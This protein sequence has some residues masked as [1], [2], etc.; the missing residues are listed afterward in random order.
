MAKEKIKVTLIKSL[1][2]RTASQ[3]GTVVG[4]GLKKMH[5]TVEL[6]DSPEVRGMI[7]AV[8]FLLKVES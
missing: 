7:N 4:L 3:K 5:H 6:Q 2:G 8:D 1:I